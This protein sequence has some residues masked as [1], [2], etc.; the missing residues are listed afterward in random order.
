MLDG[1]H[2][3]VFAVQAVALNSRLEAQYGLLGH[4]GHLYQPRRVIFHNMVLE[5]LA[6][7]TE[8]GI[9]A[10]LGS[11][12]ASLDGDLDP[13]DLLQS[14]RLAAALQAALKDVQRMKVSFEHERSRSQDTSRFGFRLAVDEF[15]RPAPT[16]SA[17]VVRMD[18]VLRQAKR[19][20][21]GQPQLQ[22]QVLQ[23]QTPRQGGGGG[24]G[25]WQ[26]RKQ[27]KKAEK[28]K[29]A[30]GKAPFIGYSGAKNAKKKN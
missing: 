26:K 1:V 2:S 16:A 25:F 8:D 27:Q 11:Y 23:T 6:A 17:D 12:S 14:R 28:S 19:D 9:S 10:A 22:P 29:G 21:G 18:Y 5:H 15:E 30:S 24:T 3:F 13:Q 7:A 20:S 4:G